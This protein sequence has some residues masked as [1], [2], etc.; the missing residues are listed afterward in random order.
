M[1]TANNTDSKIC[2]NCKTP[3]HID[4]KMCP[5]CTHPIRST[6]ATAKW[7]GISFPVFF[8]GLLIFCVAMMI[9]LPR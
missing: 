8:V 6:Q 4:D 7:K 9:L 1:N 5:K 2:D 3:V